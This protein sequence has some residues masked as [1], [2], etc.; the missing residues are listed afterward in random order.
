MEATSRRQQKMKRAHQGRVR[1][2]AAEDDEGACLSEAG[3][4]NQTSRTG[5][6]V[7]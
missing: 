3:A 6:V 2:R 5:N 1:M 4:S 7:P